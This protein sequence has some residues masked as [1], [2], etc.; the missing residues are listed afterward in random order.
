MD[1]LGIREGEGVSE[2]VWNAVISCWYYLCLFEELIR[3]VFI[4]ES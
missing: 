3:P 4:C 2:R 1:K